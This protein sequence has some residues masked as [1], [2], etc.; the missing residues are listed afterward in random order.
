MAAS[1]ANSTKNKTH[2]NG[3][4]YPHVYGM[5]SEAWAREKERT[6]EELWLEAESI[7]G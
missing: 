5:L 4:L 1:P 7:S 2:M 6:D 3:S